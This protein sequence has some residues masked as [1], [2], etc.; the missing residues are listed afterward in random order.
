MN[1]IKVPKFLHDIF[2]EE[3]EAITLFLILFVTVVVMTGLIVAE[4][5][6]FTEVGLLKGILGI[7]LLADIVAGT[8]ANFSSGTSNF[9]ARRPKNR[10][11]FIAVH[12]QPVVIAWMLGFSLLYAALLWFFVIVATSIVNLLNGH[13]HQRFIAGALMTLGIFGALVLYKGD[14]LVMQVM[15][16]FFII[17]VVFS[18]GVDHERG[19]RDDS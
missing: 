8:V 1:I 11:V 15:S 2:G 5:Q 13:A 18:F 16:V 14:S 10:W 6:L 19:V 17:K 4:G 7:V 9:Y 3:T 12:V